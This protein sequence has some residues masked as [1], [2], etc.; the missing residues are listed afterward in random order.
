MSTLQNG[1]IAVKYSW[2]NHRI[3]NYAGE[4]VQ[5]NLVEEG[6]LVEIT[7]V[8]T[9]GEVRVNHEFYVRVYPPEKTLA[10]RAIEA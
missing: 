6:S 9:Y 7:A 3:L 4:P 1:L 8:L 2:N 10:E 5:K